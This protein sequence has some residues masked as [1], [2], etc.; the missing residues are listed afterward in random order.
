MVVL[1]IELEGITTSF[2]YPHFLVGRQP[3][4]PLPPPAT[5]YGHVA[6]ALGYYPAPDSFRFA[7]AFTHQGSVDD[8]EHTWL[9]EVDKRKKVAKDY[10]HPPNIVANMNPTLR[11]VFYAPKLTLY[12]ETA[13]PEQW[14]QAFLRPCYPVA[15]GRSQDL[16]SYRSVEMIEAQPAESGYYEHT[17]LPWPYRPRVRVGQGILMPRLIDPNQRSNVTWSRFVALEHRI[18]HPKAGEKQPLSEVMTVTS[19]SEPLWIDPGSAVF[20]ERQRIL[21]WHSLLGGESE[22]LSASSVNGANGI[23][24]AGI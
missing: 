6:S 21:V 20:R 1:K 19:K 18:F 3:S 16:A 23:N 8:Y 9:V 7:Y 17:L 15:L 12:L 5:I 22:S 10:P 2:R 24:H 4:F 11:Q 13:T 14:Q